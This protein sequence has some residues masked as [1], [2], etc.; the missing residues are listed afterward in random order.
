[1]RMTLTKVELAAKGAAD[2]SDR[3]K[4]MVKVRNMVG[5]LIGTALFGAL[6]TA[7]VLIVLLSLIHI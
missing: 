4:T 6:G 2:A 3:S 5:I 1:M 7:Y